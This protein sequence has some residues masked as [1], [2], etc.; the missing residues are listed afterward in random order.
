MQSA[1]QH[2]ADGTVKLSTL[3]DH[4]RHILSVKYDLGMSVSNSKESHHIEVEP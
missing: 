3:Q 4:V 1:V 2:V